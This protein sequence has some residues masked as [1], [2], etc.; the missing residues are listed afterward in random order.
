M[1]QKLTPNGLE[2]GLFVEEPQNVQKIPVEA[3]AP[4]APKSEAP[5]T[6]RKTK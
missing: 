6:K 5:A 4:E 1:A 2:V 3:K